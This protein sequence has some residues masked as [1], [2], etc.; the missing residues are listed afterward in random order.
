M[1]L[2]ALRHWPALF[3]AVIAFVAGPA[4]YG[5]DDRSVAAFMSEV[6]D[7]EAVDRDL[8]GALRDAAALCREATAKADNGHP[9]AYA[10]RDLA[11]AIDAVVS[12]TIERRAEASEH[13]QRA[14]AGLIL[15]AEAMRSADNRLRKAALSSV[16]QVGGGRRQ[17]VDNADL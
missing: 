8:L 12:S 9:D 16:A 7:D 3:V 5:A 13:T 10:F 4:A 14:L 1:K 2:R 11:D 15:A 17:L 6:L